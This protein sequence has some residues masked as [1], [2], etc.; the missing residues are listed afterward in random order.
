[1]CPAGGTSVG[2]SLSSFF[3]FSMLL[4][5]VDA[6][7]IFFPDYFKFHRVSRAVLGVVENIKY[8]NVI[9]ADC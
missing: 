2:L 7:F 9:I 6:V 4:C 8:K 3:L 5:L 1:M